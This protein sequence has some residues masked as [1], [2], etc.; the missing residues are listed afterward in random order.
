M[1]VYYERNE[2]DFY[3]NMFAKNPAGRPGT[4]D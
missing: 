2:G 1:K 4:A 3:K